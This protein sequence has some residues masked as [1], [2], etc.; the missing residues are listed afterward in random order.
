MLRNRNPR[1]ALD[2]TTIALLSLCLTTPFATAQEKVD[3]EYRNAQLARMQAIAESFEITLPATGMTRLGKLQ[4]KPLLRYGDPTRRNDEATLWFWSERDRPVALMAVEYYPKRAGGPFWLYEV[5]S[6]SPEKIS[7]SRSD[8]IRWTAREPG[9]ARQP[10][11]DA[12]EPAST[13][14][15]RQIQ[16]KQLRQR[17]TAYE[18]TPVEGR[19]E[20]RPLPNPLYRYQDSASGLFDG[21]GFAFANGT[22]PEVLLILEVSRPSAEKSAEWTYAFCQMTG[23]EVYGTLDG[24]EV[25]SR[26]EA[27]PPAVREAYFNGWMPTRTPADNSPEKSGSKKE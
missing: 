12:P 22:N 17:F 24:R 3:E 6:L 13:P 18:K 10:L 26:G 25:W 2:I 7:V 21:A 20:L 9:Q 19:I 4:S 16:L 27:D 1:C 15:T 23:G 8:E 14:A 5:V 11:S